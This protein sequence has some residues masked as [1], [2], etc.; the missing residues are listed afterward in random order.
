MSRLRVATFFAETAS[1]KVV[2]SKMMVRRREKHLF[3]FLWARIYVPTIVLNRNSPK[4]RLCV[5]WWG[6]Q[7]RCAAKRRIVNNAENSRN[8]CKW[9]PS[10]ISYA[11]SPTKRS[12]FT[13]YTLLALRCTITDTKQSFHSR[14][15]ASWKHKDFWPRVNTQK[16][17]N[18]SCT[19]RGLITQ[20]LMKI[21]ITQLKITPGINAITKQ[22]P[23]QKS[24]K[25]SD[26]R[27]GI[28]QGY[29]KLANFKNTK[30]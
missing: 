28:Q 17:E 4:G 14:E 22:S 12:G 2:V 6:A 27:R 8:S 5:R 13:K 25:C 16:S 15:T 11:A 26:R 3:L 7:D 10:E 24:H 9:S 1:Q 20:K 30:N 19:N 23:H 18:Q 29:S 21:A